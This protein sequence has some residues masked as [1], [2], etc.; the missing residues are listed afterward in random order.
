MKW[1][2]R[3]LVSILTL[4]LGA[5]APSED[6]EALGTALDN[7]AQ[8]FAGE[9]EPNGA[10][11]SATP[12]GTD[13]VVRANVYGNGDLDYYS[14]A[15]AAGDRVYAATMTGFSS[16]SADTI[17]DLLGTDGMTLIESDDD[18]GVVGGF[19]SSL[20][21][22]LLPG[23]GSFYLQTRGFSNT[24]QVRPYHLH[25]RV[26]SGAPTPEVEPNDTPAG[27]TP[28]PMNGWVSGATS[29]ATDIDLYSITLNAGDTVFA[30][31]DLDPERD[32]VEW[33][34]T[35]GFGPLGTLPAFTV[36]DAGGTGPDSEALFMTVKD[37][38]TY[39]V[40]VGAST[41]FGTYHLS[42]SVHPGTGATSNCTTYTST[43]V[44]KAFGAT[45]ATSI[46]TVPGT[47][48]VADVDVA[49]QLDHAAL[50]DADVTLTSPAGNTVGLFTDIGPTGASQMNL[51]FDDE[52]AVPV[53]SVSSQ[54][55]AGAIVNPE[56]NYRLHW[57]DRINGGGTWT[58]NLMDDVPTTNAGNL[59][60]WSIT[61]C[62]PPPV[63]TTCAS[64]FYYDTIFTTDFET[65]DGGFTHTGTADEWARGL[66]TAAPI[67]SCLSGTN[68][69]KTDLA[70]TYNVSSNQDLLSAPI[71][72]VNIQG[73]INLSW[74]QHYQ[75]ESANF[76]HAFADVQQVGAMNPTR[77][78][79]F[80]D[81]TM[82]T[83]VANP[84]VTVQESSGWGLH[85]ADISSYAGSDIELRF[86]LDSDTTGNFAG[87]AIDDV[88]VS[89]C[90]PITCGDGLTHA[91]EQ[92]DD[93]NLID[94]DGCDSNCTTTACGNAIQTTGEDCDDGNLTDGDGCD[95]NCTIT[96]C[97]N[98]IQTTGEACDDGNL[99]DGDGC[100][101][102]CTVTGCG[103]GIQTAGE[104]CDDGNTMSG[105]GCDA[106]CMNEGAGGAGG[107]IGGSGQGG[108]AQGGSAQ[109][110]SAQG[111]S[112][113]GGS[114]Q[115]G[116]AQGGAA[117]GGSGGSPSGP[118]SSS[119]GAT[120]GPTSS[121]T[122]ASTTTGTGGPGP[123]PE[124]EGGCDCSTPGRSSNSGQAGLA[125][126]AALFVMARRRRRA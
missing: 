115:G 25:M 89:G 65:D 57:F 33:N 123:V 10:S 59:T 77:L 38:G 107:G 106:L 88:T 42:V 67:A 87:Y 111:G 24:T 117:Q 54:P 85:E 32:T 72:L 110:G 40:G 74:A 118:S 102:N 86:H 35:L 22:V 17:I 84:T 121:S 34:G 13:S 52:G 48:R 29:A 105:D 37:T 27:A 26:Q 124:E 66:P 61:I 122:A 60:A 101:S 9:T 18:N 12:V 41:T 100:D 4:S 82:T 78:F 94:D 49:I 75:M 21:G 31:L 14:F 80:L 53:A 44:P 70:G 64:G 98:A 73:P 104:Q 20:A 39:Y 95:S 92:C 97:G 11:S 45:N 5:C 16:S 50:Q 68:C 116:S 69:F 2:A 62:E 103:N 76:D 51:V 112:A 126:A 93:G 91:P 125:F 120:S 114:A 36:N 99:T 83:T 63:N 81:G 30:S 113:Q 28:L 1:S 8:G 47:P 119:T 7:L 96:A 43:D 71:S 15:G 46:I 23:A 108:S 79:E 3:P 6:P 19:A 55:I 90:K 58:L 109:G 56:L